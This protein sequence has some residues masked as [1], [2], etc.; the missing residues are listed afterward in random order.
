MKVFVSSLLNKTDLRLTSLEILFTLFCIVIGMAI[1][2]YWT[3]FAMRLQLKLKLRYFQ[4]RFLERKMD[5]IGE[6]LLSDEFVFF[7]PAVTQIDSADNKE[8]LSYPASGMLRMDGFIGTAKPR[9]LSLLLPFLFF[10]FY[11][12]VFSW[13]IMRLFL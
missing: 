8:I 6:C 3:A 1:S 4:A 11:L 2:A 9:H 13:I 12:I 10:L 7:D 5:C